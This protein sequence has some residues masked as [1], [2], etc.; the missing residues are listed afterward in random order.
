MA[1]FMFSHSELC[2]GT[3]RDLHAIKEIARELSVLHSLKV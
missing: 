3:I 1:Q 2:T